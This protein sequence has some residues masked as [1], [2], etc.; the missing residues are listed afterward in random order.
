MLR[1]FGL[2]EASAKSVRV[3]DRF[4][5]LT[6][7]AFGVIPDTYRY[8]AV[9]QCDCGSQPKAIRSD[10]LKSGAVIGCGCVQ[11]ERTSTHR[12]SKNPHYGRWRHMM[13]R[14]FNPA[15][16]AY[17]D[18]GGRGIQVCEAW[19]DLATFIRELPAGYFKGAEIDRIDNDG[20]YEPGNV[21]WVSRSRN[22]DNRRSG[23][24]I[25]F[26]GKTQ[27]LRRWSEEAG[28]AEGTLWERIVVWKWSAQKALTTPA[29]DADERMA[30]ARAKRWAGHVKKPPPKPRV[31]ARYK[32]H[33]RMQTLREIADATG[34]DI[35][36]LRK[37]VQERG[38]TIERATSTE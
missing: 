6:V 37:R 22:A 4:G 14:C 35:K 15:C 16:P 19:R 18:Y 24:Q 23:R 5:R 10:G 7:V 2:V 30:I 3:G 12:L 29:L 8:M 21:R 32:F 33:G 17:P 9:C 34:I 27:S 28:I 31:L 26:R 25:R 1:Q 36:L 11:N 13:D 38:W 20:D